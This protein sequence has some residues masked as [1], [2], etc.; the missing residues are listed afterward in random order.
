MRKFATTM[1]I[2]S[3]GINANQT[4]ISSDLANVPSAQEL[5]AFSPSKKKRRVT[6]GICQTCGIEF[7]SPADLACDSRWIGCHCENDNGI[8]CNRWE[9]AKCIGLIMP[10]NVKSFPQQNIQ[11]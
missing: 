9:H 7:Q 2:F 5:A 11:R 10:H 6:E 4:S 8:K 1:H 3:D